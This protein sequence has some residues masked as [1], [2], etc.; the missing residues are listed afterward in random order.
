MSV[1]VVTDSTAYLPRSSSPGHRGISASF[2]CMSSSAVAST[3]RV[4]T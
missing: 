4:S 1:A 3:A 2:R